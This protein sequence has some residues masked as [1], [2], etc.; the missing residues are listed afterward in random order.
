M[1]ESRERSLAYKKGFEIETMFNGK[2]GY[3]G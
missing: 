3:V 2:C 1:T